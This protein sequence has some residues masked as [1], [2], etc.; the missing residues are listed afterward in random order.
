MQYS[1]KQV[2]G[3]L[4]AYFDK[5]QC[6]LAGKQASIDQNLCLLI[7]QCF[8]VCKNVSMILKYI[9]THIIQDSLSKRY[10]SQA[11]PERAQQATS[12]LVEGHAALQAHSHGDFTLEYLEGM[13]KVRYSLSIVAEVLKSEENGQFFMEIVT[14]S[15]QYLS[16]ESE[17]DSSDQNNSIVPGV[18]NLKLTERRYGM[19]CNK[20]TF[21]IDR[22]AI[23][24]E[25][26]VYFFIIKILCNL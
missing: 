15:G 24:T 21:Q 9:L 7:I 1:M 11:L 3:H 13:A 12:L 18:L 6:V 16:A 19:L 26:K 22:N 17:L 23:P 5:S 14:L 25:L 2:R 10:N 20:Q 4:K 8:E